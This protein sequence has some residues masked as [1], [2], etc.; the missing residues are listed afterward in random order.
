MGKH[1][2]GRGR[3]EN[4]RNA[5]PPGQ[6]GAGEGWRSRTRG[7]HLRPG[8]R[9]GEERGRGAAGSGA[10]GMRGGRAAAAQCHGA[11]LGDGR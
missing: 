9:C 10:R 5:D 2:R 6:R 11:G 7:G 1:L 4:N 8:W 3:R